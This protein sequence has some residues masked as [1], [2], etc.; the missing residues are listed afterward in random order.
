MK[1]RK[2]ATKKTVKKK[3]LTRVTVRPDREAGKTAKTSFKVR[4]LTMIDGRDNEAWGVF[5]AYLDD[6]GIIARHVCERDEGQEFDYYAPTH[7]ALVALLDSWSEVLLPPKE[8]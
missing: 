5:N 1:K 8:D 3:K 6:H 2:R 7:D 4:Y